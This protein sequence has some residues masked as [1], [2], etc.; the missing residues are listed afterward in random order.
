MQSGYGRAVAAKSKPP[1]GTQGV[2]GMEG[3]HMLAT[4]PLNGN[5]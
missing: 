2:T 3:A 4:R 5:R 1:E